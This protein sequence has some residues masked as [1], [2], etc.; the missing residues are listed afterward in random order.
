MVDF[1]VN[2]NILLTL[3]V[4]YDLYE[5]NTVNDSTKVNIRYAHLMSVVKD[6]ILDSSNWAISISFLC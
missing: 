4:N 3:C 1:F 5:V 6:A 2:K